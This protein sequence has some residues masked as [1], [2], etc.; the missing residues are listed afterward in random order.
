MPTSLQYPLERERD[1]QR[2]WKHLLQRMAPKDYSSDT[3]NASAFTSPGGDGGAA[4]P[5]P[6]DYGLTSTN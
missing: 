5:E 6:G 3:R 4:V 1:V 2:R